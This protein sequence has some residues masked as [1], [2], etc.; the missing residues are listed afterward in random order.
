[1]TSVSPHIAGLVDGFASGDV[2]AETQIDDASTDSEQ[3]AVLR[4]ERCSE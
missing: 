2:C 3:M 4:D 1:M